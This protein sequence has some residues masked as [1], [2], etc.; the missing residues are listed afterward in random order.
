MRLDEAQVEESNGEDFEGCD[1]QA[2]E[3]A[4]VLDHSLLSYVN[5]TL[6][7]LITMHAIGLIK[8]IGILFKDND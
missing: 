5:I 1:Q 3:K 6:L 4:S 8:L 2:F 7:Y